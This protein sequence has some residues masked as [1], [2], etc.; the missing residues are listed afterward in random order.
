[1]TF[2]DYLEECNT[3]AKDRPECLD[4]DVAYAK[5]DEGNG[6]QLVHYTPSVGYLDDGE[7]ETENVDEEDS[8]TPN[9]VLLN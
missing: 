9:V 4:L 1:M 8:P 6:Y 5:D 7:F 2:K 3:L